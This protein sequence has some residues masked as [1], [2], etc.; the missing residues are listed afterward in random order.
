MTTTQ[1]PATIEHGPKTG[2]RLALTGL[3]VGP[4]VM[5]VGDLMHPAESTDTARQAAIVVEHADRWYL[6]HLLLLIGLAVLVPGLTALTAF[7][8]AGRPRT[9]PLLRTLILGGAVGLGGVFSIE[10][11]TGRVGVSATQ[12]ILD[13]FATPPLAVPLLALVLAFFAGTIALMVTLVRSR[14]RLRWPGTTVLMG[15]LLI[16]S[17]IVSA[18]VLLS[19]VG[20]ALVWLGATTCAAVLWR[21]LASV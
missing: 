13:A 12:P 6:A 7:V 3:A 19:Q 1:A 8:A 5:T 17:E 2:W 10:M 14:R 18:Q 11:L 9:G 4:L 20:N 15:L 16:M 21:D